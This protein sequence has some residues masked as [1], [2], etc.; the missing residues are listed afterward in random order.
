M[1]IGT[2]TVTVT[3]TLLNYPT[4]KLTL[5]PFT[6]EIV[7]C[8]VTAFTMKNLSPVKDLTYTVS[9]QPLP[10][11]LDLMTLTSQVPACGYS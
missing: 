11:S 5:S 10:W 6:I 4:I 2:H 8:I 3:V 9:D 7:A 1:T